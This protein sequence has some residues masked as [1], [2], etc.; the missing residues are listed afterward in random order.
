MNLPTQRL[1]WHPTSVFWA[2]L[3][4]MTLIVVIFGIIASQ[5]IISSM[6][7]KVLMHAAEHNKDISRRLSRR[8]HEIQ[9][10][11]SDRQQILERFQNLITHSESFGTAVFLVDVKSGEVLAHSDQQL[12]L[13]QLNIT[14]LIHSPINLAGDASQDSTWQGVLKAISYNN[15]PVLLYFSRVVNNSSSPWALAVESDI[16]HLITSIEE[17]AT[18]VDLI[19]LLT[20]T[21]IALL[22]FFALRH[23]GRGYEAS[24][25]KQL[26][27]RTDELQMAHQ[28]MLRKACLAT[29]GQTATMLTH[30]MRNPLAAIKLGLSGLNTADYL[31]PRERRRIDIVVNEVDRLDELL[32]QTLDYARPIKLSD[33]PVQLDNLLNQVLEVIQP[34]MDRKSLQ[35]NR[36]EC[37]NCPPIRLDMAQMQQ[38]LLNVLKNAIEASPSGSAIAINCQQ[39]GQRLVI[40]VTNQGPPISVEQQQQLFELF[41]T[42]KSHG[43]GLGLSLVKRIM[44]EHQGGVEIESDAEIG[45]RVT[46]SLPV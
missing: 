45:T 20:D 18:Q 11:I 6:G 42:T 35:L 17:Q 1:Q 44:E 23:I 21:L 4:V 34:L 27:Q 3:A 30:E 43:T 14:D 24:L 38:A 31:Q 2:S 15:K 13:R 22:G 29:I 32:S 37:H 25:E 26:Q 33:E 7:D 8:M 39:S 46:L 36:S 16:T 19:L 5:Q 41:Y 10:S 12:A 9:N 40:V 28:E